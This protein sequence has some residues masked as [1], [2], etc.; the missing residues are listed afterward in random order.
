MRTMDDV[1]SSEADRADARV[2]APR[3][4]G[5]IPAIG[6]VLDGKYAVEGLLGRGGMGVV[7]AARHVHLGQRV[8]VKVMLNEAPTAPAVERFLREGVAAA[9]LTSEHVARVLD[10][11]TLDEGAPYIVMEYLVGADAATLLR[12]DGPMSV[13]TAATIVLHACAG[14]AEA[15]ARGI[16][17]RDLKP[18]NLFVATRIDGSLLVKVLDFGI[19]KTA[20]PPETDSGSLTRDGIPMGSPMYMSPEQV[21]S[22]KDVDG[23]SDVW[24]LGVILYELL[25]G[26]APF[27]GET[28][29]DT[30]AQILGAE[31]PPPM[32][33]RRSGLPT[34]LEDAVVHCLA[35]PVDARLR[36]VGELATA[37]SP[38]AEDGAR[39]AERVRRTLRATLPVSGSPPCTSWPESAAE[40]SAVEEASRRRQPRSPR[41]LRLASAAAVAFVA[42]A[43]IAMLSS[44]SLVTRRTQGVSAMALRPDVL[45]SM[46]VV[47]APV[48]APPPAIAAGAETMPPTGASSPTA[49]APAPAAHRRSDAIMH[50][51]AAGSRVPEDTAPD[52]APSP[53]ASVPHARHET[54][55]F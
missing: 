46:P 47:P 19:S 22:A 23:R 26:A 48:A 24:S 4:I 53:S 30:Y 55:I 41:S 16:V 52:P 40:A 37:L 10:M 6:E 50:R 39:L 31:L 51:G 2:V 11:G 20:P 17:H 15:H 28:L 45:R 42:C 29:A 34:A 8:A 43:A 21:R 1:A 36:D 5:R 38:W 54:D 3:V 33:R 9:T 12:R 44:P 27:K 7:L 13:A 18:A 14:V 35:R 49:G 25:T 32:R